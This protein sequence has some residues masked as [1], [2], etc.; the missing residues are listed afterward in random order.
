MNMIFSNI[1]RR[2]GQSLKETFSRRQ[3]L[4]SSGPA[5]NRP[6]G[7]GPQP[8]WEAKKRFLHKAPAFTRLDLLAVIVVSILVGGWLALNHLGERG[9]IVRC[10]RNLQV[11]GE[12]MQSFANDHGDTL[13]PAAL[14]QMNSTWDGALLPYLGAAKTDA[15]TSPGA[16]RLIESLKPSIFR[17]LVC[18][19]DPVKRDHP[20]SYAMSVY[21]M[22]PAN[23]PPGP[24]TATGLGLWW[25]ENTVSL[26]LAGS[27]KDKPASL[28]GIKT[29]ILP[30]P[31]NTLLLTEYISPNHLGSVYRST[32]WGVAQQQE[33]LKDGVES[34][35]HGRFN[36]LMADGH[37]ELLSPLQ[38]GTPDRFGGIWTIKK[39]D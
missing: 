20:R 25:D 38:T 6:D 35:H 23:W 37:V 15:A 26:L 31:A 8:G 22:V 12:A 5:E 14:I 18:P 4:S 19:S 1:S 21:D 39:G 24:D 29:S 36:Y 27:G 34:I 28:P 17:Q 13:P 32:V 10:T 11:L 7:G 3:T 16:K 2:P 30:D 33:Y 9:R